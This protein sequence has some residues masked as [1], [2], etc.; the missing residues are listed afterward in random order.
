MLDG[1]IILFLS[2]LTYT[3]YF[4]VCVCVYAPRVCVAVLSCAYVL[5]TMPDMGWL[6]LTVIPVYLS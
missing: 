1:W 4:F 3:F 2:E 5:V 6:A